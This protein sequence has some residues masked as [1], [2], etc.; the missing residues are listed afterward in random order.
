MW[1]A[2]DTALMRLL[3]R[4]NRPETLTLQK[5]EDCDSGTLSTQ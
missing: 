3:K 5:L 2:A 4:N 1:L